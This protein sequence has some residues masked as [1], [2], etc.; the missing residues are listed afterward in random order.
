MNSDITDEPESHK[1]LV[2]LRTRP[3]GPGEFYLTAASQN[4]GIPPSREAE[5]AYRRIGAFLAETG[6]TIV[7][8]RVYG[9]ISAEHEIREARGTALDS[10]QIANLPP[11]TYVEGKPLTGSGFAGVQI[12]AAIPGGS[13]EAKVSTVFHGGQPYGRI[14]E[15][16]GVRYIYLS[17]LHGLEEAGRSAGDRSGEVCRMFRRA[18]EM[19]KEL[20]SSFHDVV[21][22]WIYITDIL[23]WYGE[24][25]TAR[26]D[27]FREFG[28]LANSG[29]TFLPASTGIGSRNPKGAACVSDL[30]A[31]QGGPRP[32]FR[33]CTLSNPTQNEALDYR[34]AFS[35]GLWLQDGETIRVYVSGCAAID[36]SGQSLHPEN[37]VEQMTRTL[38]NVDA[39]LRQSGLR[40]KDLSE[41]TAFFKRPSDAAAFPELAAR[42]G[43]SEVPIVCTIADVCRTELLFEMDGLALMKKA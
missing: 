32:G 2:S 8:E 33:M 9:E 23:D 18:D 12:F 15:Y 19:L 41:A 31:V 40:L 30:M 20:G 14:L 22:T 28:L 4:E 37:P 17:G 34:S 13:V 10:N 29:P 6:A 36:E 25:N 3:A 26:N 16:P 27:Q 1:Q 24:F 39:L 5:E 38:R 43:L 7:Q 21:R 42:Y 11:A 35:R